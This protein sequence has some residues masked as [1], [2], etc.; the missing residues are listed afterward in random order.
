MKI[1]IERYEQTKVDVYYNNEYYGTFNNEHECDLFRI[2]LVQN[3]CTDQYHLIWNDVKINFN[4]FGELSDW[5]RG[6]YDETQK[7]Y[8]ELFKL[9]KQIIQKEKDIIASE[10]NLTY[11]MKI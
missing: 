9:R 5:P 10:N 4:K 1:E 11:D 8:S 6:M 7:N 2:K 3:N